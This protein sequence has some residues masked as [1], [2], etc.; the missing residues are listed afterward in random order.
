MTEPILSYEAAYKELAAIARE[1][2]SETVTVDE[3][4]KKV[5][6]AAELVAYCQNKLRATEAEVTRIISQ[7]EK[8]KPEE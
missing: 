5:K 4:A 2:E 1:I 6:R 8:T 3:L 7:M